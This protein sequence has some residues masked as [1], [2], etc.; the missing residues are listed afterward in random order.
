MRAVPT[1]VLAVLALCG[2]GAIVLSSTDAAAQEAETAA[3]SRPAVEAP[4]ASSVRELLEKVQAGWRAERIENEGREAEF[5][6][7]KADQ[8]QLLEEARAALAA[9]EQRSESLERDFQTNEL[10]IAE[11]ED[12]LAEKLGTLGELF[13]VVRQVAGDTAGHLSDSLVSAQYPD[14]E[15]PILDLA[16]SKA[17]PSIGEIEGL[18]SA[19]LREMVEQGEVVRFSIAVLGAEGSSRIEDVVRIGVFNAVADGRYLQWDANSGRLEY[20]FNQPASRYLG[21]L[22]NLNGSGGPLRRVAIDPARGSILNLLVQT[23]DLQE[24]IEAGGVIGYI[25][26]GLGGLTFLAALIRLVFVS[27]ESRK[28]RAQ[29][30]DAVPLANNPLGRVMMVFEDSRKDDIETLELKLDE[31]VLRESS[32][33]ERF[34]WAI[35]VVS[36]V[37]PL[38]GLLGTVTGMIKTFQVITLFG[39]GDP[40]MMAGG[41]SEALV[42]TMLGLT[43]AIPLVLLHSW[44]ASMTKRVTSVLNEQS[45]G[46]IA[47]RSERGSDVVAA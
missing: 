9:E 31:A 13:G 17:L 44:I 18:W 23:P 2:A 22:S 27:I 39:A 26:I 6:S 34:L 8:A 10:S 28:V 11:R 24:R 40:K 38:L 15:Q 42:T 14:R 47:V 21:T 4:R 16:Q 41:I 36:V 3:P 25:I 37:A 20:L 45:A 32:R 30:R 29:R 35:K 1:G 12:L 19:M 43:V 33:I 5:R 7:R 46:L